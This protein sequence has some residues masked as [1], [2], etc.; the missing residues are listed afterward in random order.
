VF[1][2]RVL[3]EV[4]GPEREEMLDEE[5]YGVRCSL[6]IT[7]VVGWAV[8]VARIGEKKGADRVW[9]RNLKEEG[10]WEDL[11]VNGG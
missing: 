5:L 2:N 6:S 3:K 4:F 1:E 8:H 9:V 10:H 11:I 7:R